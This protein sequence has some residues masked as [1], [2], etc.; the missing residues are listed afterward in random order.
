VKNVKKKKKPPK[1]IKKAKA[2]RKKPASF[3]S[4]LLKTIDHDGRKF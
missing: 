3:H 4:K 1:V 2:R